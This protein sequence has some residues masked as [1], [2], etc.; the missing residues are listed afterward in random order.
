MLTTYPTVQ[1]LKAGNGTWI[2]LLNPTNDEVARVESALHLKLPSQEELSE[3]KSSSRLSEKA[4]VLFLS[5][6]VVANAHDLEED[7][8]PLGFVLSEEFLVTIRYTRLRSFET[9]GSK[10]SGANPRSSIDTFSTLVEEMVDV[11]ADLLE[12]IAGQLDAVSKLVFKKTNLKRGHPTRSNKRLHNM[13]VDVG[14]AGERLSRVRDSILGLQRIVPFVSDYK[15]DWIDAG[16]KSPL[17][18]AKSDIQSLAD[19]EI[20][21]YTKVQFLL[22][23]TLGFINTKQNDIFTVL[24]IASVVGI[25]PTLVAS[26]YGMNFKNMPELDW[27]WGYQFG[28]GFILLSA[29]VPIIWLKWRGWF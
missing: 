16:V 27:A 5:M 10:F 6:P 17:D 26:I 14:N 20:H 9:V 24:T 22:D 11:S 8:S 29:I 2:D 15:R 18:S 25:P 7:P 12:E 19:Y 23:A 4:G 3:I 21:L 28:L 1:D 13:L